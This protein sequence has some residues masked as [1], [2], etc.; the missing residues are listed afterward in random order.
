M[1]RADKSLRPG[2]LSSESNMIGFRAKKPFPISSTG[3]QARQRALTPNRQVEYR[4]GLSPAVT[5]FLP[6]DARNPAEGRS[7]TQS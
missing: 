6:G 7:A 4:W 2:V 1:F 5:R 3:A